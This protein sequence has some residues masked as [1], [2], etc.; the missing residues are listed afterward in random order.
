MTTN[1]VSSRERQKER[2]TKLPL[3]ERRIRD[4]HTS[5]GAASDRAGLGS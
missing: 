2:P 1:H 3:G 5:L 4:T